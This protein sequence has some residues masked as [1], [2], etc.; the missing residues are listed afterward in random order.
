MEKGEINSKLCWMKESCTGICCMWQEFTLLEW[1][2]NLC[3]KYYFRLSELIFQILEKYF[4]LQFCLGWCPW[5]LQSQQWQD[6]YSSQL[7][8]WNHSFFL[9]LILRQVEPQQIG[10]N[11]YTTE[12]HVT[13]S[14]NNKKKMQE[15]K[16]S[17]LGL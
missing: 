1:S 9:K 6:G 15:L 10:R 14:K 8:L 17:K 7:N 16:W 4:Q 2:I 3:W 12:N 11:K 13:M 5:T